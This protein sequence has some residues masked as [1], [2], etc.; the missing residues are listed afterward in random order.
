MNEQFDSLGILKLENYFDLGALS[1]LEDAIH[2]LYEMQA[3]KIN[4]YRGH[5][6]LTAI[7]EAMEANDKGALY[8]VQK[9]IAQSQ[10]VRSFFKPDLMSLC[11]ELLKVNSKLML[12][13]GPALFISRP[14]TDRLLYK[15]HSEAHY[16]PKRRKFVNMWFPIYADRDET[17]GAMHVKPFTHKKL[18]DFAEYDSGPGTFV[19]YEIPERHVDRFE[20]R[21]C[22]SKRGDLILFHRN[23]VHRSAVNE[24]N[25]YAFAIVA[26]AWCPV[27]DL[28]L[29]GD[30]A[31]K[32]YKNDIGRAGLVVNL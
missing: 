14:N 4:D 18:W 31:T 29:S 16:Y 28:T 23:L 17:N 11:A 20:S 26:R 22:E 2:C 1:G 10:D 8:Q 3:H 6:G 27:D 30:M 21:V 25:D 15:W 19:Q 9:M 13:E 7:L 32:P 24:S 12:L 5:F